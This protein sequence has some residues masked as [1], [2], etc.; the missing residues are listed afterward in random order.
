MGEGSQ[1][2]EKLSF[3]KGVFDERAVN[4]FQYREET[5]RI[6]WHITTWPKNGHS[7]DDYWMRG[8]EFFEVVGLH[9][10]VPPHGGT[11]IQTG[12]PIEGI[13]EGK[14]NAILEA[15]R[16]WESEEALA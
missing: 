12:R 6:A 16:T 4:G 15:I 1:N 13:E 11:L 2:L 5:G 3:K 14:K 10:A 7:K 9:L 8:D